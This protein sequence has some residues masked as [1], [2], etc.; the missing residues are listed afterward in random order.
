MTD[1]LNEEKRLVIPAIDAWVTVYPSPRFYI[2]FTARSTAALPCAYEFRVGG[3]APLAISLTHVAKIIRIPVFNTLKWSDS[4]L[5]VRNM[6]GCDDIVISNI[7]L[8]G[9]SP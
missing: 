2:K 3:E 6:D 8:E 5:Q 1:S 7:Y 4:D 9:A